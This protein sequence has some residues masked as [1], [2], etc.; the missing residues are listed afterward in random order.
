[1]S[2]KKENSVKFYGILFCFGYWSYIS[3]PCKIFMIRLGRQHTG[4]PVYRSLVGLKT[5]KLYVKFITCM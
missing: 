3:K 2:K 1:M 5:Q 4:A